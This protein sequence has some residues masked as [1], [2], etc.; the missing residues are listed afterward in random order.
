M[1]LNFKRVS[2]GTKSMAVG[3]QIENWDERDYVRIIDGDELVGLFIL[4]QV[5]EL[6]HHDVY[7]ALSG[8]FVHFFVKS[9]C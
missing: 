9:R 3:G 2:V 1:I 4:S 5:L 6:V 7:G 8:L